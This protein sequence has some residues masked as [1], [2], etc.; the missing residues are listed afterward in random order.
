M[1]MDDGSPDLVRSCLLQ[2]LLKGIGNDMQCDARNYE[3]SH[4]TDLVC[5]K[6]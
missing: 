1:W 6:S 4:T 3:K 5:Y 2:L